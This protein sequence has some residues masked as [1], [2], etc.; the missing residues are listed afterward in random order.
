MFQSFYMMNFQ[1]FTGLYFTEI[2]QRGLIINEPPHDKTLFSGLQSIKKT[3]P[4]NKHPLTPHLYKVK[5][6]LTGVYNVF[7]FSPQKHRPVVPARTAS[8]RWLQRVPTINVQSKKKK[9]LKMN[10]FTAEKYCCILHG[11]VLVMWR[12][13]TIGVSKKQ[14]RPSAARPPRS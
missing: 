11:H 4:C 9:N 3:S 12:D 2:A 8:L 14:S 6:G 10:T 1:L 7:L 13:Y 5:L